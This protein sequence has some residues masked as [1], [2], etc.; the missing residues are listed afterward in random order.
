MIGLSVLAVE[1][2]FL[3]GMVLVQVLVRCEHCR[4]FWRSDWP[5]LPGLFPSYIL[6]ARYGGT[7]FLIFL[8][9]VTLAFMTVVFLLSFRNSYW[10]FM[11]AASVLIFSLL[12]VLTHALIA[13]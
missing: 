12:A 11:L 6:G 2:P 4:G 1:L 3:L 10:R 13:A 8:G 7:Q 9:L 5:I